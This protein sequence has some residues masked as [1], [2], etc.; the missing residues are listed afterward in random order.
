MWQTLKSNN[1]PVAA[2][3]STRVCG[4][5]IWLKPSYELFTV[6]GI[7]GKAER[8]CTFLLRTLFTNALLCVFVLSGLCSCPGCV[9]G[10]GYRPAFEPLS[11]RRLHGEAQFSSSG[12][13]KRPAG[14]VAR[15]P[16]PIQRKKGEFFETKS[17]ATVLP[18][19]CLR[20]TNCCQSSPSL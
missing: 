18:I 5:R 20:P 11:A 2:L 9:G 17:F 15:Q 3:A 7:G 16:S 14:F 1:S 6:L 12:Q 19:S 10:G 4:L 8:A 13:Q